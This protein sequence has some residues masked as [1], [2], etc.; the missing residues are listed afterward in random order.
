MSNEEIEKEFKAIRARLD[1]L[2]LANDCSLFSVYMGMGKKFRVDIYRCIEM[3]VAEYFGINFTH[4]YESLLVGNQTPGARAR[5]LPVDPE[6][7]TDEYDKIIVGRQCLWGILHVDFHVAIPSLNEFYNVDCRKYI[8]KWR[9]RYIRIF[10]DDTASYKT[11][12]RL[13]KEDAAYKTYYQGIFKKAVEISEREGMYNELI[14]VL[15]REG[16]FYS[17]LKKWRIT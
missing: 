10:K 2:E 13:N 17:R 11:Q 5:H 14:Q 6:K 4:F 12:V 1:D 16:L 8:N 15:T 7:F 3:A 9:E